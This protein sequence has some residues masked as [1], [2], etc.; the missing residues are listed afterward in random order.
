[1]TTKSFLVQQCKYFRGNTAAWWGQHANANTHTRTHSRN[2]FPNWLSLTSGSAPD[3]SLSFSTS[4][5]HDSIRLTSVG[6]P[7]V[8][9]TLFLLNI[10]T[11]TLK[12]ITARHV[13]RCLLLTCPEATHGQNETIT[14]TRDTTAGRGRGR[15]GGRGG[16]GGRGR[17]RG[18]VIRGLCDVTS[19]TQTHSTWT[20]WT[21]RRQN[22][23]RQPAERGRT[24]RWRWTRR[25]V[26][27]TDS[28]TGSSG[29]PSSEQKPTEAQQ[30]TSCRA[31]TRQYIN[32]NLE[33]SSSSH[34]H[35]DQAAE[36]S[37]LIRSQSHLLQVQF[38][39]HDEKHWN[40]S[41]TRQNDPE[42]HDYY[43][44]YYYYRR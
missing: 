19:A 24:T 6:P 34:R 40:C 31:W 25:V 26:Q 28:R 39:Y 7:T 42:T 17:G 16:G 1:M 18:Q 9:N 37:E 38:L 10:N 21:L 29:D 27:L 12:I 15:V 32:R 20:C 14:N 44:Y 13:S 23:Q 36:H 3:V 8:S 11:D 41:E 2:H 22:N 5:R 30:G 4:G 33:G 35:Q 43:Y